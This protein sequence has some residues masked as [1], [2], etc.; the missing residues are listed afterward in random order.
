MS[1]EKS[2]YIGYTLEEIQEAEATAYV[3]QVGSDMFHYKGNYTFSH[4][5]AIYFR[6][7][8]V[9][10]LVDLIENGDEDQKK[11]AHR[12]ML[13]LHVRPLRVH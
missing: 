8:I 10:N 4:K 6:N 11:N 1:K 13:A 12:C 3:I 5:S 9:A 7:K 2:P